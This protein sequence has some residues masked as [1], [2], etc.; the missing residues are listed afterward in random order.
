MGI[1]ANKMAVELLIRFA[2]KI[3]CKQKN[4]LRCKYKQKRKL[5]KA[6]DVSQKSRMA[7]QMFLNSSIYKNAKTIM[8]YMP[9]GNETDTSDIL[10]SAF[11]DGKCVVLPVTDKQSGII[12]PVIATKDTA[13][14]KGAFSVTE[15]QSDTLV[16]VSQIDVILV[17]GIAF[18]KKGARIGFGKGCFDM[19]LKNAKA[20][21]V[22]YCYDF[23]VVRKIPC[24][25]HD[26]K[27]NYIVTE[28]KITECK[29]Y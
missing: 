29:K 22:G 27:M 9:L 7:Q 13:Y 8:L 14:K 23:Q 1:V 6:A 5:M 2:D 25:K 12:T 19:L 15:P 26:I 3:K 20:I 10:K 4:Q 28:N 16:D 11:D 24:E 17:P 21:K 18:D